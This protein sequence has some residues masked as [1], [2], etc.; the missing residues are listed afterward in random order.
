[1]IQ[2]DVGAANGSPEGFLHHHPQ[3]EDLSGLVGEAQGF[4]HLDPTFE[5]SVPQK[6]KSK[7]KKRIS[8]RSPLNTKTTSPKSPGLNSQSPSSPAS[9]G[10]ASSPPRTPLLGLGPSSLT[11]LTGSP[12]S[13]QRSPPFKKRKAGSFVPDK[14][15]KETRD[16]IFRILDDVCVFIFVFFCFSFFLFFFL[17]FS[18][19]FFLVEWGSC[20]VFFSFFFVVFL[21]VFFSSKVQM[22][23]N[24]TI[25]L[26][27]FDF[28]TMYLARISKMRGI[29]HK[30]LFGFF[31]QFK[32]LQNK[33]F[34]KSEKKGK[35]K[36]SKRI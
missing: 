1:M 13:V 24:E 33:G 14:V 4:L 8:E 36:R 7:A 26:K 18:S 25:G 31:F 3:E 21:V 35:R 17:M 30:S 28:Q 10:Y 16:D 6:K 22:N 29:P 5:F 23:N 15:E 32:L 9:C 20:L 11:G 27:T 12:S 34:S 19:F 2:H